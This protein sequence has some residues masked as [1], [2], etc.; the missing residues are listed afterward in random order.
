VLSAQVCTRMEAGCAAAPAPSAPEVA[1]TRRQPA[2]GAPA[3][4]LPAAAGAAARVLE[5]PLALPAARDTPARPDSPGAAAGTASSA[6]RAG[7]DGLAA[8]AQP[9]EHATKCGAAA[10]AAV[11][12]AACGVRAAR[13]ALDALKGLEAH[14]DPGARGLGNMHFGTPSEALAPTP[15]EPLAPTPSEPWAPDV[16][17][18]ARGGLAAWQRAVRPPLAGATLEEMACARCSA[19]SAS[20]VAP[21]VTLALALPMVRVAHGLC[22]SSSCVLHLCPRRVARTAF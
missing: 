12:S 2:E 7:R 21:F 1:A 18:Q 22:L 8:L 16:G 10:L 15:S 17:P 13:G 20:H 9:A 5:P 14:G 3:P 6:L 19:T 11:R 4:D